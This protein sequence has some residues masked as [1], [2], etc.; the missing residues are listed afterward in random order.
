MCGIVS[1]AYHDDNP[2]LG[3]EAAA[4]LRRLE[5][6]GYDST[7][8]SFIDRAGAISLLKKVGSPTKV[9]K[10]LG[11]EGRSGQR[12]IGQV[13]WATYGAATDVNSQPHRVSC[14]IGMVG[15]H[16][17]NV[18]NTD[19]LKVL[20]TSKGHRV[21]SDNDGEIIVHLVEEGLAVSR[22]D[23]AEVLPALKRAWDASGLAAGDKD[24]EPDDQVLLM[25]HAIRQAEAQAEGS[26]AAAVSDPAVPGVFAVKSGSS[27]YAGQGRDAR[28]DF[29][30]VSSDLS[31]VLSKTRTLIPLLEGEGLWFTEK[32]WLIFTLAGEL[33]F[34]RPRLKRSRLNVR[35]TAL[36]PRYR[37]FMQQE[38]M[39]S[40][41]NIERVARYYF[42]DPAA[43]PLARALEGLGEAVKAVTDALP[44]LAEGSGAKDPG[45]AL[46]ALLSGRE[47]KEI[48]QR[49]ASLGPTASA[50]AFV[51]D[52][53]ELLAELARILP[54]RGGELA[55]ADS[56][57]VW[58]KRR[59][60]LRDLGR[61]LA[62]I[63]ERAASGGRVF[64]V[65]SGTSYHAA[66]TAAYFFDA[67][68][69][70]PVYP[71]NPGQ[72]RSM[73]FSSL[74]SRDLLFGIT[75]SGETK[76]LVDIFQDAG[77]A[78]PGLTRACLVNNE[79]SRIPQE[80][81]DFYLPILCG[82]ETAVAAT[83]SFTNQVAIL[84]LAAAS[85]RLPE[86]EVAKGLGRART[87]IDEALVLSATAVDRAAE[88]LFLRPSLHILGTGLIGLAREGALKI[89]EVV[90]NHAEGYDAAEFKHGP[91]TIL[92]KNTLFSVDDLVKALGAYRDLLG[93][94]PALSRID[95][96]AALHA[97]PEILEGLFRD[98]PLVFVCPP[99]ERD[100]RITISQIHTHKIRGADIILI[101]EKNADLALA[102]EGRPAG[103][104]DWWS[105]HIEVP[106]SGDRCLFVFA[107]AALLQLLAYRMSVLKMEYLDSLKVL[108]HGV[109]PDVPKNVSKSITVD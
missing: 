27:L 16:N 79:N 76:D 41:A 97:H 62:A 48:A 81:S 93:G 21:L 109:H 85:F 25:I 64:L 96:E 33:R 11:V 80:L 74:D 68:A 105:H 77:Q 59:S 52:E 15:A 107:A 29:V 38:I 89:R 22:A 6:R 57:F 36:D 46:E 72:F 30:V 24:A 84:Y 87:L 17:G 50:G 31:S 14:K 69:G 67:L 26:Y 82:P 40:G 39:G 86:R 10:E 28:G 94:E 65:A 103:V 71:C 60:V 51:S 73:Y 12:F 88:K 23:P 34:A 91:N 45:A 19:N 108:D 20:L 55:L 54:A 42:S 61:F 58:E 53:A 32:S 83:K 2:D 63:R 18:S 44:A 90:L 101:A 92:G 1:L 95:P 43:E 70:I 3:K 99:D 8:A 4:L 98:Y 49:V 104:K 7:G 5:Y 100:V 56:L 35:D 78:A 37:H 106:A 9:C 47:W 13:R 66:L 102:L 75:Q